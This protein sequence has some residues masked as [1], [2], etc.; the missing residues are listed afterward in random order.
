MTKINHQLDFENT[1]H[2]NPLLFLLIM[3]PGEETSEMKAQFF[4][5]AEKYFLDS[6]FYH[7]KPEYMTKVSVYI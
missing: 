4:E 3:K 1:K 5:L 7:T 2:K 6:Y